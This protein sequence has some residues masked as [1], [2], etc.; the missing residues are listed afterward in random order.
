MAGKKEKKKAKKAAKKARK[1]AKRA[2]KRAAKLAKTA[3]KKAPKKA[4]KQAPKRAEKKAVKKAVKKVQKKAAKAGAQGLEGGGEAEGPRAPG[5]P[6][7]REPSASFRGPELHGRQH[8]QEHRLLPGRARLH[9]EGQVGGR[10]RSQGRRAPRGK[11]HL[12]A[13]PGR[14]EEGPRPREGRGLAGSTAARRRTSTCWR[15]GVLDGHGARRGAERPVV[16]RAGPRRPLSDGFLDHDRAVSSAGAARQADAFGSPF[17]ASGRARRRRPVA[18]KIAPATAGAMPMIGVS[19]GPAEG[20][21]LRSSSTT[22]TRHVREARHAVA[23]ELRAFGSR[24]SSNCTASNS[25]P[26]EPHHDAS[27]RPGS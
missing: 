9:P 12:L 25:A 24:R 6:A 15:L 3:P 26:A 5:P 23:R 22:S 2:E 27:L 11:R 8:R 4:A 16:G 21:S 20:R 1:E 17:G 7:A 10:G 13:R 18:A 14:L 19:P